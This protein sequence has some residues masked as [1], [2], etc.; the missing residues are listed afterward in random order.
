MKWLLKRVGVTMG[1]LSFSGAALARV[2]AGTE[3]MFADDS[4]K[5]FQSNDGT[6]IVARSSKAS[7]DEAKATKLWEESAQLVRLQTNEQLAH[8]R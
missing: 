6:L 5:Y 7:Y 4:G 8:L 1:S 3:P 2:V